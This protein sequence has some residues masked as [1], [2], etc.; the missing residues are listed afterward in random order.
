M[1]GVEYATDDYSNLSSSILSRITREPR[2]PASPSHPL[3]LLN[4]Q[5]H[6]SLADFTII[7]PPSPI[8]S[9]EENF[10]QLGIAEDHP[11]RSPTDTYYLNRQT[12][13]RTHTSAHEVQTFA[14]GNTKW[15]L[16]ADVFRRDEIDASHYPIFHQ[17]EGACIYD[18]AEYGE[19][20]R[21]VRECEAMEGRLRSAQIEIEDNVDIAEAGGYQ[22]SHERDPAKRVAAQLAMR[23]LKGTLNNLVLDLFGDRH[24]AGASQAAAEPLQVRW[25]AAEF[26]FTTPSFEVEVLFRGKLGWAFGLGLERIAMVLFAIPDIRLFWSQDPRFLSQFAPQKAPPATSHGEHAGVSAAGGSGLAKKLPAVTFKPYSKYPACYKDVSFWLPSSFHEN[27]LFEIIRDVAGDLTEDVVKIDDFTHPTTQKRSK[28]YR[29]NYR[30]MDRN[31]ENE[32]VNTLHG[33]VTTRMVK[34][35]GVELR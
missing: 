1:L 2:L 7:K 16:T 26:P 14:A 27:D 34:E 6:R 19:G 10:G 4:E 17:M 29:I 5:I 21:V 31:L 22:A 8:V 28:C 18:I 15:T 12:C 35:L 11:G 32:E 3:Q 24:E 9:I 25:I 23:H 33:I 30:S 13:L 20:Q